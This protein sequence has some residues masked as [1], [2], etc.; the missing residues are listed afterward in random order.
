MRLDN[1]ISET[2]T[3]DYITL[4]K[5]DC[6]PWLKAMKNC[7]GF[8]WRGLKKPGDFIRIRVRTNRVPM[9]MER[10][11]AASLD[12]G[13]QKKFGWKPRSSGVFVSGSDREARG[14]SGLAVGVHAIFPMGDFKFVWS[15]F[16]EDLYTDMPT[17]IKKTKIAFDK[18]RIRKEG[19]L[20]VLAQEMFTDKD[21]CKARRS[22]N[23]VVIGCK[24]Y[25]ALDGNNIMDDNTFKK[26]LY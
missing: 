11:E 5:R 24:T 7:N 19:V 8:F 14:Y 3:N 22:N 23:E 18:I 21:L 26:L 6:Q 13:F 15:P 1:Y 17:A 12:R 10:E 16:I 2:T 4:I 20:E 25:Y 9:N